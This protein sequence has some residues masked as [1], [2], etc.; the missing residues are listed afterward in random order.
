MSTALATELIPLSTDQDGVL[1]IGGTR[2]TLETFVAAFE[3]GA[4]PEEIVRDYPVLR[5]DDIY[6]VSTYFLRH[7]DEVLGYVD[8]RRQHAADIRRQYG[9]DQDGLRETLRQRLGRTG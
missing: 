1:R 4:T 2:V 9:T 6:A 5:L 3:S 8:R 7:R